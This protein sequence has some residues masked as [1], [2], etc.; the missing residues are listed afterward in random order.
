MDPLTIGA[1]IL[2][3]V[4]SLFGLFEG[5]EAESA[6]EKLL[7]QQQM[8][9]EIGAHQQGLARARQVRQVMAAQLAT[10]AARG[11]A[12]ESSTFQAVNR[13]SYNTFLEDNDMEAINISLGKE[14]LALNKE[15]ARDREMSDIWST[16]AKTASI[17]GGDILSK[18]A[19]A[20]GLF[21]TATKAIGGK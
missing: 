20:S 6:Q 4:T 11:M 3:G 5:S 1:G 12:P 14:R 16:F 2:T 19:K 10:T 9:E 18:G 13:S 7:E 17:F 15:V 8:Q 21:S